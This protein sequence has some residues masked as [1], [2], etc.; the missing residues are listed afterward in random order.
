MKHLE[1]SGIGIHCDAVEQIV[2]LLGFE[3]SAI[4]FL[5]FYPESMMSTRM[6]DTLESRFHLVSIRRH[7][8]RA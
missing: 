4:E 2:K 1:V 8:L 3:L 6:C 7:S 5:R